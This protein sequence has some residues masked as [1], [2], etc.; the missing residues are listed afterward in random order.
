MGERFGKNVD[1]AAR[2]GNHDGLGPVQTGARVERCRNEQGSARPGG[3]AAAALRLAT[4]LGAV[5]L[6]SVLGHRLVGW[7]SASAGG[8]AETGGLPVVVML[9]LMAGY[10]LLLAIPFVPGVELGIALMMI[11]GGRIAPAIYAATVVGL[12]LAFL[13]GCL[14]PDGALVRLFAALR[15]SAA[16]RLI[17]DIAPLDREAR[18]ARLEARLPRRAAPFLLR[19]RYLL[20]AVLINLPGSSLLGGGGGISMVAGMSRLCRPVAAL[21][22]FA[23]AVAPVPVVVFLASG[24]PPLWPF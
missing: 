16:R 23:L 15:L 3:R 4:I 7:I 11:E 17:E 8:L 9:A 14:V 1:R 13:A 21:A 19:H 24:R 22:T 20:L 10:A 5:V 12:S 2:A 18:L 6:L